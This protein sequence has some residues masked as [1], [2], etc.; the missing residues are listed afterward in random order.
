MLSHRTVAPHWR[1]HNDRLLRQCGRCSSNRLVLDLSGGQTSLIA[2]S[3]TFI[4]MGWALPWSGS[5]SAATSSVS[6]ANRQ[7]SHFA[8]SHCL[9]SFMRATTCQIAAAMCLYRCCCQRRIC[10]EF[11]IIQNIY[12][13]HPIGCHH[14]FPSARL[15]QSCRPPA[16]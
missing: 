6:L 13:Y 4:C 3:V 5:Y 15:F 11:F 9:Q 8:H 16:L 2:W 10:L 1:P 7:Q 14:I 12:P